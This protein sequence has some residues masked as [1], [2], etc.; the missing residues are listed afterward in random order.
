[1]KKDEIIKFIENVLLAEGCLKQ[2]AINDQ[3]YD[4]ELKNKCIIPVDLLFLLKITNGFDFKLVRFW[5]L[6]EYKSLSRFFTEDESKVFYTDYRKNQLPEEGAGLLFDSE[7]KW[8]LKEQE[9]YFIFSDYNIESSFWAI[10]LSEG[11]TNN[12]ICVYVSQNAYRNVANS[13]SE[14][15]EIFNSQGLEFLI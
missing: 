5:P 3:V 6:N 1:M 13:L 14:F 11:E 2:P 9:F 10:N 15:I 4:F 7:G 8:L 12:V